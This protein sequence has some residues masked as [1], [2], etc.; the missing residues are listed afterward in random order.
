MTDAVIVSAARTPIG[1]AY[2][3]LFNNT[4]AP[5]M[6]GHAIRAAVERAG[7]DPAEIDD[8]IM[9]CAMPQGTTSLNIGRMAALAGGL[10]VS[11]SGMTMDRQCSSGLMAIATAAKQILHDGMR[12]AVGAGLEQISL[13]QNEHQNGSGGSIRGSRKC[14][15]TCICRCCRRRKW[16][17]NATASRA[18]ARTS[19]ALQSQQRTAAG[20]AGREFAERSCR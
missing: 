1:K 16:W 11:V 20:A 14:T 7:V 2:R 18:S 4:E 9:G 15:P 10:P 5:T 13:V 17:R 8:V 3:G 6:G 12:V 19:T